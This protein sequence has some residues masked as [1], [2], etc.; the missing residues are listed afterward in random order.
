MAQS[1]FLVH[2]CILDYRGSHW[3]PWVSNVAFCKRQY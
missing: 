2:T 1:M 3:S